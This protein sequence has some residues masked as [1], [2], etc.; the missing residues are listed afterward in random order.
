MGRDRFLKPGGLMLPSKSRLFVAPIED[1]AWRSSKVDIWKDVYGIDMSALRPLAVATACEKPQHRVVP[2]DSLLAPAIEILGIDLH[3]VTDKDLKRFEVPLNF[4]VPAGQKL[5]G[6]V[7]WFE[8][9]FGEAGCLLSTSPTCTPTHW[10][11][12]AFYFRQPMEGGNSSYGITVDG[13]ITVERHE[14]YSRGYRVT[15]ELSA[16]GHKRR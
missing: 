1:K 3:T 11:Q 7:S 5:D 14:T 8:C 2:P 12:T 4:K 15:F 13:L 6:F 10:R 16:P 9:D